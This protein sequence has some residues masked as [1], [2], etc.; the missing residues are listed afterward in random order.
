YPLV[1]T[2]FWVEYQFVKLRPALYHWD[3]IA[4]HA[5]NAILV[6]LILRRLTVP[7]AWLAA[8]I[9]AVHPVHVESVAWITERKNVLSGFFYLSSLWS[10]LRFNE[11]VESN[12]DRRWS[13]Y[14]LAMVLYVAAFLSKSVACSLPAA[15]L[16]ILWW[17][18]GKL[19]LRD[20]RAMAP[21]FVLGVCSGLLTVWLEK[22]YVRAEGRDFDLS[23]LERVLIAGRA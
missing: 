17:Q 7:G 15:V 6:W 4:L 18:R 23:L 10:Y 14:F 11:A 13:W 22:Y 12:N 3:N 8:V 2:S 21:F 9:F 19:T 1:F 16:L 5:A 20:V